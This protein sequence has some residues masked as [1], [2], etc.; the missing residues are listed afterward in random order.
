[1]LPTYVGGLAAAAAGWAIVSPLP[2]A[3]VLGAL[4]VIFTVLTV[5]MY[6]SIA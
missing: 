1:M 6:M 4:A 3:L 2:L 5:R